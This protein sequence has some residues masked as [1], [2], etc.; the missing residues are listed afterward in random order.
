MVVDTHPIAAAE[1]SEM[2]T[3]LILPLMRAGAWGVGLT[4]CSIPGLKH[5]EAALD[6]LIEQGVPQDRLMTVINR[7][8]ASANLNM[9]LLGSRL[10]RR[11]HWIGPIF[12]DEEDVQNRSNAG[13]VLV[14]VNTMAHQVE[15]ILNRA[16]G[17]EVVTAPPGETKPRPFGPFRLSGLVRWGR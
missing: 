13:I 9:E 7:V 4:D 1:P 12:T 11:S 5:L 17:L 6:F 8:P 10:S 16:C 14:D 15:N 3:D 2:A